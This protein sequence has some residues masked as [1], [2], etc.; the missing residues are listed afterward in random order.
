MSKVWFVRPGSLSD[1]TKAKTEHWIK[2]RNGKRS[3]TRSRAPGLPRRARQHWGSV[4]VTAVKRC[5]VKLDI[6]V[7]R[8][9]RSA[10]KLSSL[11]PNTKL[12]RMFYSEE[13]RSDKGHGQ[14]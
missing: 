9:R 3:A 11:Q 12:A 13:R 1:K 2:K 6:H 4:T 5:Q 14:I 8:R 7:F 10:S